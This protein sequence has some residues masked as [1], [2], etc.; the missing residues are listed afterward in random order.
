MTFDDAIEQ[1]RTFWLA[2]PPPFAGGDAREVTRLER[3]FGRTLPA[4]VADYVRRYAP[5]ERLSLETAGNPIDLYGA[6]E[7]G[8]R[9]D[10][11]NWNPL[12]RESLEGW[13]DTWLLLGD[14]GADPIVVDL[15]KAEAGSGRCA[16]LQAAHGEGEWNFAEVASSI[17]EFLVLAAAQHH[18]LT[19]FGT[20]LDAIVDDERGFN[21]NEAAAAWYF[22]F[23]RRIAPAIWEDWLYV[24]DNAR[25]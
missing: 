17:P 10:G 8:R 6:A 15:A 18:A 2:E 5:F 11:Y 9:V 13:S 16:V 19:A 4:E 25:K 24:F 12:T 7:L 23:V 14:E 1:I 20:R 21:L 22:P 3:E